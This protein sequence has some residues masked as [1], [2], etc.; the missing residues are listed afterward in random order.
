MHVDRRRFLQ[1]AAAASAAVMFPEFWDARIA[2]AQVGG[3]GSAK[4][5]SGLGARTMARFPEKADLILLT[6]RPP[7][8]ETPLR[9]FRQDITPNDSF[10]VRW[11]LSGIPVSVDT[12]TFRLAVDGHVGSPLSLSIDD[13]K[14][15]FESVSYV[16]VAQC[17][18]NSRGLFEPRVT[19]GQWGHGAVGNAKWTGVRLRD[20]LAKAA[21]RNGPVQV[22]FAG[23]DEPPIEETPKFVK[24]LD[25]ARANDGEVIVAYA[26]N[27]APLPMLNGFPLRL[28]VP[29]WYATYWVKSL[30]RIS[31]LNEKLKNFWMDKAYRIPNNPDAQEAPDKLATDTVPI[32]RHSVR[33]LIVRP[34]PGELVK[35]D[36]ACEISGVALDAGEGITKVEVSTDDAKSWSNATL[37]D[38]LGRYSW[39]RWRYSW[40]PESR[41]MHRVLARATN[42][43]GETQTTAQWNRSGYQRSVIEHLDVTVV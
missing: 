41:G 20:I 19:G 31:V 8:L 5:L 30:N 3:G 12:N 34:E 2:G 7:Q 4:P 22:S 14:K 33:S 43:K 42:A 9:V 24:A 40:K 39:R 10:F 28:I 36:S 25:F 15:N 18:G 32:S 16:A 13:L 11:H 38:D 17:S 35:P 23:L 6:D 1:V 27:D 29:G 37:G 21:V 26:M